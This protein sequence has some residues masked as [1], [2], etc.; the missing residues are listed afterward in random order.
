MKSLLNHM[1]RLF[2]SSAPSTITEQPREYILLPPSPLWA[3]ASFII[4]IFFNILLKQAAWVPDFLALTL[5]FWTLRQPAW[6][7]MATAFVLGLL[8]DVQ[9]GALLGQHALAYV[10]LSFLV[11]KTSRRLFW[12]PAPAQALHLLPMFLLSQATVLLVRSWGVHAWPDWT[13]FL[14]SIFSA[15]L[16]PLWNW[17]LLIPQRKSKNDDTSPL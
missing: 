12:F 8:M 14:A 13:W 9:Q 4:A 2:R 1:T 10:I 7:G 3:A 5:V 15:M 17:I 11:Q 16:W 6:I